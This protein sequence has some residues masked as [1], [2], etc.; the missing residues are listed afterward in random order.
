MKMYFCVVL[1]SAFVSASAHAMYV[2]NN[3]VRYVDPDGLKT[4][5]VTTY[6]YGVGTHSGVL[7]ET[8]GQSPFL[9]DP[10]GSYPATGRGSGD[11]A[12]DVKLQDYLGYHTAN[13]SSVDTAVLNTSPEQEEAIR[14]RAMNQGGVMAGF[15]AS[16]V[17]G[18]LNGACGI[19]G[20]FF[21]GSL[22]KQAKKANC[23]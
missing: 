19:Q 5:V 13:G 2:H 4:T 10:A 9:Y 18:A 14:Q 11:F 17:S 8:P 20:S 23:P 21:P 16:A 6:D 7:V 1:V 12:E 15:C 3:P 22:N